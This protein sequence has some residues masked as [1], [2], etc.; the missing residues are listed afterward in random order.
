MV[1]IYSP[2]L[3]TFE[4]GNLFTGS[5]QALRFRIEPIIV[6]FENKEIDFSQS[7]MK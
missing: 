5:W 7:V 2:T 3:H 1:D 4:M 6:K